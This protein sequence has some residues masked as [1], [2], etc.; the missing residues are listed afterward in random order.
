MLISGY[1]LC[2]AL[3]VLCFPPTVQ[4][5]AAWHWLIVPIQGEF[6]HFAPSVTI[7]SGFTLTHKWVKFWRILFYPV[8][9]LGKEILQSSNHIFVQKHSPPSPPTMTVCSD[10]FYSF[11]CSLGVSIILQHIETLHMISFLEIILSL[12]DVKIVCNLWLES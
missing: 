1:C 12:Y 4:K 8:M 6:F 2:T 10:L 11:K 5:H 3:W 9:M 7:C